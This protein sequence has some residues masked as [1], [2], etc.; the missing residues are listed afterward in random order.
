MPAASHLSV[1]NNPSNAIVWYINKLK[2]STA[3]T[4]LICHGLHHRINE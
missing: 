2:Y 3:I 1:S 4:Q